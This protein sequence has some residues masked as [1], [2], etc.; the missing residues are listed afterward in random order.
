MS[1]NPGT[2]TSSP[3][4]PG[5][6]LD[7]LLEAR[8]VLASTTKRL[9]LRS[10]SGALRSLVL[11]VPLALA[12]IY[13]GY[14]AKVQWTDGIGN[15]YWGEQAAKVL[16]ICFW[17]TMNWIH[18][19][20][21]RT[22]WQRELY[23]GR[24]KLG[25]FLGHVGLS[26]AVNLGVAFTLSLLFLIRAHVVTDPGIVVDAMQTLWA[27]LFIVAS[28]T[29]YFGFFQTLPRF[30]PLGLWFDYLLS[31][32]LSW[33]L[34]HLA[35]ESLLGSRTRHGT[36]LGALCVAVFW[37]ALLALRI[38]QMQGNMAT[39]RSHVAARAEWQ[40]AADAHAAETQAA[41]QR[42]AQLEGVAQDDGTG[43][44]GNQLAH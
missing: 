18:R 19:G 27:N 13:V 12:A 26:F 6:R 8:A 20:D 4:A 5:P 41:L 30:R 33:P 9:D 10:R 14:S 42:L 36:V 1:A 44:P 23:E 39:L 43:R 34:P 11:F 15:R 16:P 7:R 40:R 3:A 21:A 35:T 2:D 38:R 25:T 28:Y 29:L 24:S 17:L 32:A 31:S 22:A 37:G